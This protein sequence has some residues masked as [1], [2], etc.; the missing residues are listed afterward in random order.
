MYNQ[1][2]SGCE[3]HFFISPAERHYNFS[4]M[5]TSAEGTVD[6]ERENEDLSIIDFNTPGLETNSSQLPTD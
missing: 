2:E 5:Q 4:Q 6:L 3:I 1:N